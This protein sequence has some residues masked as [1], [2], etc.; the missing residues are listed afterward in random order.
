M[1]TSKEYIK[2]CDCPEIQ[3]LKPKYE[4]FP[5]FQDIEIDVL[6]EWTEDVF[7]LNG[8]VKRAYKIV[9]KNYL[10]AIWLPRQD[11]LHSLSKL[12]WKEFDK[13]CGKYDVPTK[14]QAGLK[15]VMKLLFDK[16]T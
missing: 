6:T 2:M 9:P 1:D 15:V 3:N 7:Y 5:F 8:N 13:E 12:S 16:T 11:Q 4:S 10:E 14:E